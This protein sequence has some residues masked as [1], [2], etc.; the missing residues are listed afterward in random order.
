MSR[1]TAVPLPESTVTVSWTCKSHH[2]P[3]TAAFTSVLGLQVAQERALE[4]VA[5]SRRD[6]AYTLTYPE[7][8]R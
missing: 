5:D 4:F 6:T 3:H 1:I 8:T 2:C 7:A